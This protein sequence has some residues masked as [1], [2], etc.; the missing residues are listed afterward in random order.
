MT[1]EALVQHYEKQFMKVMEVHGL[2]DFRSDATIN[3]FFQVQAARF[4]M[5]E[6]KIPAWALNQTEELLLELI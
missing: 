3:A 1:Q 2:T 5:D 6:E 4:G